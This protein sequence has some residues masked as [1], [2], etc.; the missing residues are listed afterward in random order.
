MAAR[1]VLRFDHDRAAATGD[2]IDGIVIPFNGVLVTRG[3]VERIGLPRAEYFIWG[4]DHEYRLRAEA[5]GAR[6]ATVVEA[7]KL[8]T[9]AATPEG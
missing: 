8:L 7:L 2:R 6:I 9:E 1:H 5:A 4:D 3:L